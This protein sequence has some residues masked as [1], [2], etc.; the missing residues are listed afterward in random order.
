MMKIAF[1][2]LLICLLV[3]LFLNI[4]QKNIILDQIKKR[5]EYRDKL[6]E[7]LSNVENSQVSE[8]P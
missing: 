8:Q 3:M 2:I 5:N 7:V 6:L 1:W 4:K